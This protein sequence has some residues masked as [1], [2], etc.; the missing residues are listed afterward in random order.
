MLYSLDKIIFVHFSGYFIS[1]KQIHNI[2]LN[3]TC[4]KA[5]HSVFAIG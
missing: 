3:N 1:S 2:F 4:Q 5:I